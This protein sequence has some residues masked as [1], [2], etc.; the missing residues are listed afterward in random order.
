MALFSLLLAFRARETL[1]PRDLSFVREKERFGGYGKILR[2]RLFTSFTLAYTL[3]QVSAA[4]LWILLS[5]YAKHNYNVPESQYGWI[6]TTNALMVVFFQVWITGFT[7]RHSPPKVMALGALFYAVG[8]GSVALGAGF[9]GFWLC[10]VIA[11]VGEL[12]ITPTSNTFV[13]N[14]APADMRGRYM[15]VYGLAHSIAFG[16]GPLMGGLI[17]DNISPKA[18]WAAGGSFALLAVFGFLLLLRQEPARLQAV[19]LPASVNP[20]GGY[21]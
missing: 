8:V 6:P 16:L 19:S 1:P 20:A 10:M 11:T 9:W 14:L 17:N 4:M 2:D 3:N 5:V 21:E 15:S 13:A 7:K 18:T 12:V